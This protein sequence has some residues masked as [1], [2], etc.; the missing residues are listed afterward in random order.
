MGRETSNLSRDMISIDYTFTTYIGKCC[1]IAVESSPIV[2][3]HQIAMD[4]SLPPPNSPLGE[5]KC[6]GMLPSERMSPNLDYSLGAMKAESE[7]TRGPRPLPS[8]DRREGESVPALLEAEVSLLG[9]GMDSGAS[10][11]ILACD[12]FV[13]F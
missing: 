2:S 6:S 7:P 11:D 5:P 9:G 12:I 1:C 8:N 10:G 3:L 13:V 4:D